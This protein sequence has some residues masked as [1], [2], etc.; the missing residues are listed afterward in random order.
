[1]KFVPIA[2]RKIIFFPFAPTEAYGRV[3]GSERSY[4]ST[5]TLCSI[6][7]NGLF[8]LIVSLTVFTNLTRADFFTDKLL[9]KPPT[10]NKKYYQLLPAVDS[11][12]PD[13]AFIESRDIESMSLTAAYLKMVADASAATTL[14]ETGTFEGAT[15]QKALPHFVYIHSI[16]LDHAL[17]KKATTKFANNKHVHLYQGDSAQMLPQI[18]RSLKKE[19]AVIFLD[20][21]YSMGNTAKGSCNT[22]I[23]TE[24]GHIKKSSIT[25]AILIIDDIRMFYEPLGNTKNTFI[26]GYPTLTMIVDSIL[27]INPDYQCAIVYDTLIAFPAQEKIT[28]S[29]VVHAATMSRLYDGTNYLIE[30][31]LKAELTIAKAPQ[32][33]QEVIF[34]LGSRWV[35]KWSEPAGLSRHYSLWVG[36]TFLAHDQ[37]AQGHVWLCNAKKRGLTDWRV[38]W[39]IALAQ[40]E[41]FFGIR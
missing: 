21:H 22:P 4:P 41:C 15:V 32:K 38:E 37:Y 23:M 40:A 34:D 33:E 14:I 36:L 24:L 11:D 26:E 13:I 10:I 1:M 17:H 9:I 7:T 3:E 6:G 28:V 29:P 31:V 20:A 25:N 8:L 18:L 35:E 19:K 16:E 2:C 5:R 12:N 30:D 27:E 39:Y